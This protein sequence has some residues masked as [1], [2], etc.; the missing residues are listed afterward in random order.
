MQRWLAQQRTRRSQSGLVAENSEEGVR[1][2][3]L[4]L[5]SASGSGPLALLCSLLLRIAVRRRA[6]RGE[7]SSSNTMVRQCSIESSAHALRVCC[8]CIDRCIQAVGFDR[9]SWQQSCVHDAT[10]TQPEERVGVCSRPG[11]LLS[12]QHGWIGAG[13]VHHCAS[14]HQSAE[15]ISPRPG[16]LQ[17][18]GSHRS[19][20]RQVHSQTTHQS[21]CGS[22]RQSRTW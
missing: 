16:P 11:P 15:R 18:G 6:L 13:C 12:R 9:R 4:S 20:R 10:Q 3:A 21:A 5:S 22:A 1:G 7:S 14:Q 2:A 8:C 19:R 17:A